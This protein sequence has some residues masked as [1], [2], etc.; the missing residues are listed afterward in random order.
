MIVR[1][2]R[3]RFSFLAALVGCLCAAT[4]PIFAFP[5]VSPELDIDR[6]I[7]SSP[8]RFN[9]SRLALAGG[10]P[11]S[12]LLVW[13]DDRG[14]TSDVYATR[15]GPTGAQLDTAGFRLSAPP[16]RR[17]GP[18]VAWN[19]THYL[20]VWTE[21]DDAVRILG[22]RVATDGTIIDASD[23]VLA[24][25]PGDRGRAQV[26]WNGTNFQ[27][28]WLDSRSGTS[29]VYTSRV[30]AEGRVLDPLG[31]RLAAAGIGGLS[32]NTTASG[33]QTFVT[34]DHF[35]TEVSVS[36]WVRG[37]RIGP[38]GTAL[39]A[40]PI[41]IPVAAL[42]EF[43]SAVGALG[44]NYLVSW[45]VRGAGGSIDVVG[46]RVSR[47]GEVLDSTPL[48]IARTAAGETA[49]TIVGSAS[50]ARVVWR[51]QSG[52]IETATVAVD[53][54][55][56]PTV[57]LPG[58]TTRVG[59]PAAATDGTGTLCV[60]TDGE[61]LPVRYA[62][63]GSGLGAIRS[64]AFG[65]RLDSSGALVDTTARMLGAAAQAEFRPSI[66]WNGHDY[67]V[68]WE[69][70]RSGV[71]RVYGARVGPDGVARDRDALSLGPAPN[72]EDRFPAVTSLGDGFLV[73]FSRERQEP[74]ELRG[75]FEPT[76]VRV[77]DDG[78]VLDPVGVSVGAA[79]RPIIPMVQLRAAASR[80]QYLVAWATNRAIVARR[81]DA[82]ARPID[83][84][85]VTLQETPSGP[86][87]WTRV[88]SDGTGFLVVWG[89][90]LHVYGRRLDETGRLIDT[91]ALWLTSSVGGGFGP[92]IAYGPTGYVVLF[93]S[94]GALYSV[95]VPTAGA[96]A[97]PRRLREPPSPTDSLS[98]S[99]LAW[100]GTRFVATFRHRTPPN[101][102]PE[103]L[104]IPLD[105]NGAM[106]GTA[107][108]SLADP[109]FAEPA[110]VVSAR[111]DRVAVV[112]GRLDLEAPFG[113]YRARLRFVDEVTAPLDGGVMIPDG[114]IA[115]M[116]VAW[117]D[118]PRVPDATGLA[119]VPSLDLALA[120]AQG[121]D[122]G[123]TAPIDV[124]RQDVA[125]PADRGLSVDVSSDALSPSRDVQQDALPS[126]QG[127]E[128]G[129]AAPGCGCEV[130]GASTRSAAAAWPWIVAALALVARR[131][132]AAS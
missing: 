63:G 90:G 49:P 43:S 95:R 7:P 88:A 73:T 12:Y 130:P 121:N 36:G 80:T 127:V 21:A 116:D 84:E 87:E 112:Y 98:A 124:T 31:V 44:G 19:G 51:H 40:T 26:A 6:P 29:E 46:A 110:S 103:L 104:S 122:A 33:G 69:D 62:G 105:A 1:A 92:E 47:A 27:V 14:E 13:E 107:G 17:L 86:G 81:L 75:L 42:N 111:T 38:E 25:A 94:A 10:S 3:L 68:V 93:S 96:P 106:L 100:D 74:S 108:T 30:S 71:Y 118:L 89:E 117:S 16:R 126:D 120:D 83:A 24:T 52:R 50:A 131:R 32:L 23:I 11:G 115:P 20:V 101:N 35:A 41:S 4:S 9:Q 70:N 45:M 57:A 48:A 60:W 5:R 123:G 102:L 53:G 125:T 59:V 114:G 79:I 56:G 82:S 78:R 91:S 67:F 15:I 109:I 54:R 129:A 8:P 2:V 132:S 77:A 64:V 18:A 34:W 22:R 66:A 119:D 99:G 55:V 61:D 97:T 65:A 113:T 37:V 28:S 128:S 39:D 58:G 72:A 85:P 76:V